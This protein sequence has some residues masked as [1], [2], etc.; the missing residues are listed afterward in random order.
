VDLSFPTSTLSDLRHFC[1]TEIL[2]EF[3]TA[4]VF[5]DPLRGQKGPRKP[6]HRF[7]RELLNGSVL[8]EFT[9]LP[10]SNKL[11]FDIKSKRDSKFSPENHFRGKRKT[12]YK[13]N[14]EDVH[15]LEI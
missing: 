8:E 15:T 5:L 11:A 7:R 3:H 1:E 9:I 10:D 2:L 6:L 13:L 14:L 12:G 4:I